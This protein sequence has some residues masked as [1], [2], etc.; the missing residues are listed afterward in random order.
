MMS[1]QSSAPPPPPPPP[2]PAT[3]AWLLVAAVTVRVADA[4]AALLPAG[5]VTRALAGML[6]VYTPAVALCT[7]KEISQLP[8]AGIFA[9]GR[10]PPAAGPVQCHPAPPAAD[11][12]T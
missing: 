4:G 3:P 10:G 2:L 7:L 9:P 11:A 6:A 8:P 12:W 5:P 1:S